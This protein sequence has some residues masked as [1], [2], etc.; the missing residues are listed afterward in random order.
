MF[1]FWKTKDLEISRTIPGFEEDERKVP[2]TGLLLLIIMFIAGLFFG[3]RALDDVAHLPSQPE[4]ISYCANQFKGQTLIVE[5]IVSPPETEFLY[6]IDYYNKYTLSGCKFNQLEISAGIPALIDEKNLLT[7][8]REPL[9]TEYN[10]TINQ[11]QDVRYRIER[12]REEYNVGLQEKTANVPKPLY[13]IIDSGSSLESLRLEEKKLLAQKTVLDPK[14]TPYDNKLKE[15]D[16]K[17]ESVYKPVFEAYNKQLRWYEFKVFLLQLL[18]VLPF[19]WLVFVWYLRLHKKNSPYTLIIT[20]MV[21]VAG[22]LFLRVVLFWFW[23]LFLE[24]VLRIISEWFVKYEIFRTLLFYGGMILSFGVFGGAVYY[25]QKKIFD[26]RRITIRR[27][28]THQCPKCQASL[29]LSEAYCPN[30]GYHL[31]ETCSVCG[32]ERFIDLPACP[33]CGSQKNK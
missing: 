21:M 27:F 18:F 3:W 17:I 14:I 11:L 28:R 8:E 19:F 4:L 13:P 31:K 24:E 33:H 22:V 23:G 10:R 12:S 2:K 6:G 9:L 30:C 16:K 25:L 26:P 29:E 5:R 1:T 7:K 32:K 20:A 15:L